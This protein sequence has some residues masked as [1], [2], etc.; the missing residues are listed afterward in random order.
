MEFGFCTLVS[1]GKD[2]IGKGKG[3]EEKGSERK[4]EEERVHLTGQKTPKM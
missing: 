4:R 3:R 1:L 2:W